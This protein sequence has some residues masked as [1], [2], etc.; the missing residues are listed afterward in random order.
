MGFGSDFFSELLSLGGETGARQLLNRHTKHIVELPVNDPAIHR[1]I[2][3]PSD[4]EQ[5]FA[6]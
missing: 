2:D 3:F 5:I 6:S 1:D 4:L